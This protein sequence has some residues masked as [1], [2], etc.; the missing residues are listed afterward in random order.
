[1]LKPCGL[2]SIG[3]SMRIRKVIYA[4]QQELQM[5]F[6]YTGKPSQNIFQINLTLVNEP[7]LEQ[8]CNHVFLSLVH[9]SLAG[10][11][12]TFDNICFEHQF[13]VVFSKYWLLIVSGF[14]IHVSVS[15]SLWV[16]LRIWQVMRRAGRD[17]NWNACSAEETCNFEEKEKS[18]QMRDRFRIRIWH[19][20]VTQLA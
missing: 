5:Q 14:I 18:R 2:H 7:F 13:V 16:S 10:F 20:H 17:V 6:P 19:P 11:L 9:S 12:C 3:K 1:M 8:V 4:P 15:F